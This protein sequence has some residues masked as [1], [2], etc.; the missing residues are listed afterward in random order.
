M[1]N[2]SGSY[3]LKWSV[4]V[5]FSRSRLNGLNTSNQYNDLE[6]CKSL[7]SISANSRRHFQ[8]YLGLL[9]FST[10]QTLLIIIH[11]SSKADLSVQLTDLNILQSQS[12]G[13]ERTDKV[14]E[15]RWYILFSTPVLVIP[16]SQI[17]IWKEFPGVTP[18]ASL[19]PLFIPLLGGG[20]AYLINIWNNKL[21]VIGSA[22]FSSIS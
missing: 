8:G 22:S 9:V 5:F 12:W 7:F 4:V 17:C 2:L 13:V 11:T 19:L 20:V 15:W 1:V 10:Q 6:R 3:C 21:N 18:L 16:P 14:D